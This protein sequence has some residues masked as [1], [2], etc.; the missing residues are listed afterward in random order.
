MHEHQDCNF[1]MAGFQGGINRIILTEEEKFHIEAD[2]VLPNVSD[3]CA[4]VQRGMA[5]HLWKRLH[6]AII[7]CRTR[8]LIPEDRQTLVVSGGVA[9]NMYIRRC[10]T[11]FC[12]MMEYTMFCPPPKLC[13]DNGI[14]I[15]W[16]GVEKLKAGVGIVE[17]PEN[18]RYETRCP[19]GEDLS[20]DVNKAGIRLPWIKFPYPEEMTH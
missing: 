18:M 20:A 8:E 15:A 1:S 19:I 13:T 4:S 6:R 5:H 7:Y 2:G 11:S 12:D 16:N 14:M 3:I 10:L 17:N 9:C